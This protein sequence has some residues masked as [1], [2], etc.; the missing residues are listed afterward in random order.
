MEQPSI[1]R[2]DGGRPRVK[3]ARVIEKYGLDGLGA[4]LERRW[5]GK[6]E[7]RMSLRDLADYFNE[8]VLE[9]AIKGSDLSSIDSDVETL[10]QQLTDEDVSAGTRTR[11]ERRLDRNGVDIEAITS[12][13]VTHQSIHTYLRKYRNV[14]QPEATPEEQLDTARE[15][16]QKLQDRTAAVTEDALQSLQREGIVPEGDIDVLVDLQLV[17]TD[18]G[19]QYSVFEMLEDAAEE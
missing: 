7:Q 19:E 1:G 2:A 11:V 9:A 6:D 8:Q 12:D 13:F 17:Y 10:Y 15:R 3:V 18:T 4:E 14:S 5:L 16:I